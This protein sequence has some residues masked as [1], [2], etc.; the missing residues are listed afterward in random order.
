MSKISLFTQLLESFTKQFIKD[1]GRK[2]QTRNELMSIQDDVVRYLNKK[3]GVP[4]GP[5]KSPFQG[6]TPELI[7]G[8]KSK[9]GIKSIPVD[10]QFT[11]KKIHKIDEELENLSTGEGKYGKMNRK[12]RE[13]EMIRLQD[14]SSTLQEPKGKIN[15]S[16]IEEKFGF[17]LQGNESLS[18]LAKIE[19]MGRDEYYSSLANRA[20]SIRTRM[21]RADA[22]GG[23]EIAYQEFNKLQKELDGLEDFITRVQKEIPEGM[24]SGGMARVGMF[25]GGPIVKGGKWFLKSLRDTRKQ[26]KTM[27]MSPDQLKYYL[28]Q[29]DDQ[30]KN[31]EAGGKIPDEVI[32]TIRKDS[33]FKSVSQNPANDPD[34]REIEEVLLEYGEKHASG[35]IAGQLHMNRQGYAS[36]TKKKKKEKAIIDPNYIPSTL[37]EMINAIDIK[38]RASGS[39]TEGPYGPKDEKRTW[40]DVIGGEATVD[41]PGGF[42]LKGDYDKRRTKDRL[43]S[44]DDEFLDKRVSDDHDRW[45]L[46]LLWKKKFGGPKKLNQGGRASSGL[47][48]LLGEDDQNVRMPYSGLP[49]LLGE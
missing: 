43:Y 6:F 3:K 1:V 21:S 48:Y 28:N 25:G 44:P 5:K 36:G 33:K 37:E 17:P 24:A 46:E 27:N 13:N 47:N 26:M 31:I 2:P 18:E 35:G 16:V 45:K 7:Q 9:E 41:L 32:Q 34:L 15:Y 20:M 19:K 30:I 38:P 40:S 11:T 10:E 8:G 39:F 14:E 12:D 49:G 42:T 4:E 22:E 29:I 23:T